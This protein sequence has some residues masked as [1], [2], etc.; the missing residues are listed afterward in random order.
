MKRAKPIAAKHAANVANGV[1][2]V[3]NPNANAVQP[4]AQGAH[5]KG[6]ANHS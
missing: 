4:D 3:Q 2:P 6:F 1:W 5:V